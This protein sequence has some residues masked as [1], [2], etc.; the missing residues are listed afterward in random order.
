MLTWSPESTPSK[1]LVWLH[2][3]TH[4]PMVVIDCTCLTVTNIICI[5]SVFSRQKWLS[6]FSNTG[7][8]KTCTA[9][10]L[11][12]LVILIVF[13]FC[14]QIEFLK[15]NFFACQEAT[16]SCGIHTVFGIRRKWMRPTRQRN[17]IFLWHLIGVA[18]KI[19][20]YRMIRGAIFPASSCIGRCQFPWR[21]HCY[22]M[23]RALFL[24]VLLKWQRCSGKVR[25]VHMLL[26]W[27]PSLQ[28]RPVPWPK[29]K[30]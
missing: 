8:E 13:I 9:V 28:F 15:T 20:P 21:C 7:V 16:K 14:L 3:S 19:I 22:R 24:Q 23:A 4:S 6:G 30:K 12:Y 27:Q 1:S 2:V 11:D 29:M 25:F 18:V 10:F 26:Y 5:V 17:K